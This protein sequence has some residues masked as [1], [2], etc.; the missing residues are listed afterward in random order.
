MCVKICTKLSWMITS[1]V[2]MSVAV[3]TST[4]LLIHGHDTWGWMLPSRIW[5][6]HTLRSGELPLWFDVPR[7][8]FSTLNGQFVAGIWSPFA[9][10]V[11]LFGEYKSSYMPVEFFAWRVVAFAGTYL[12]AERHCKLALTRLAI[13]SS[14][15]ASGALGWAES[16][17]WNYPAMAIVPWVIA[18]VDLSMV[19]EFRARNRGI[20]LAGF[21]YSCL[22][23]FGYAGYFLTLPMLLLPYIMVKI[24]RKGVHIQ[25]I[26]N[27][28]QSIIIVFLLT[29]PIVIETYIGNVFGSNLRT[30]FSPREGMLKIHSVVFLMFAN[31]SFIADIGNPLN[32]P[33]Y[34]GIVP[35]VGSII[36]AASTLQALGRRLGGRWDAHAKEVVSNIF[37]IL[38]LSYIIFTYFSNDKTW[39]QTTVTSGML[40]IFGWI[41]V[42]TKK[43]VVLKNNSEYIL[44]IPWVLMW[45]SEEFVSIPFRDYIFPFSI[46]RFQYC[47]I[48]IISLIIV[49]YG[50]RVIEELFLNELT[51]RD[52]RNW[53]FIVLAVMMMGLLH[54][55]ASVAPPSDWQFHALGQVERFGL[56]RLAL[57]LVSD[58]VLLI[59]SI[60][61]IVL[62]KNIEKAIQITILISTVC[63]ITAWITIKIYVETTLQHGPPEAWWST[64]ISLPKYG[65]LSLEL[66]HIVAVYLSI[67]A[68][69]YINNI[70]HKY[71]WIV[72][73]GCLDPSLSSVRYI[74]DTEIANGNASRGWAGGFWRTDGVRGDVQESTDLALSSVAPHMWRFP[75]TY[76]ALASV[77]E[78]LGLPSVF[79]RFAWLPSVWWGGVDG[80]IRIDRRSLHGVDSAT[81]TA[82]DGDVVIADECVEQQE[83]GENLLS[84]TARSISPSR[85]EIDIKN[86][87]CDRIMLVT[88][89][90][91]KDWKVTSDNE[92]REVVAINEEMLGVKIK[93]NDKNIDI[94][95]NPDRYWGYFV[96]VLAGILYASTF[97]IAYR[98][99]GG[100]R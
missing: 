5:F 62:I 19:D 23:W 24:I 9:L 31:P 38:L 11:A 37:T 1:V 85:L 94:Y 93:K 79:Q 64:M 80:G 20:A 45:A 40:G 75:G 52:R 67:M 36:G 98:I 84:A 50:W 59:M 71:V 41:L 91:S 30:N 21:S 81:A 95:Y 13:A 78:S 68:I 53:A 26:K 70:K 73:I 33:G 27:I 7:Y 77:D 4:G 90:F 35:F 100:R 10:L 58:I 6:V 28:C 88:L 96:S 69:K 65:R 74:G 55:V 48:Y 51:R 63:A 47:Q 61:M 72:F 99:R 46:L 16:L 87:Q 18:G 2:F 43:N 17:H 42:S 60:I 54:I 82:F 92:R 76:P 32:V 44:T 89:P 49:L 34:V 3:L 86:N 97:C 14:Y 15:V 56:I 83:V 29:G 66:A 39:W 8:G 57:S 25:I 12:L 22:V